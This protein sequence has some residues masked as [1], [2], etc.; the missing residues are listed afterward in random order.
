[1]NINKS[2]K[3]IADLVFQIEKTVELR[4]YH[5]KNKILY[6]NKKSKNCILI[7]CDDE[8]D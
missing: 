5:L 7:T 3:I 8:H 6:H 2:N 1:M 4:D